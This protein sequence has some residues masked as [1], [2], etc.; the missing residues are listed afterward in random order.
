MTARSWLAIRGEHLWPALGG[1]CVDLLDELSLDAAGAEL[2]ALSGGESIPG[3]PGAC[4]A[5]AADGCGH[6]LLWHSIHGKHKCEKCDC[7]GFVDQPE[8]RR[9]RVTCP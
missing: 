1:V 2:D 3:A 4:G 9:K 7:P 5:T 6:A 8:R